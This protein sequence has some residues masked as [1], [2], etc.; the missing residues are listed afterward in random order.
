MEDKLVVDI[1]ER[2]ADSASEYAAAYKCAEDLKPIIEAQH[3]VHL[4]NEV[5]KDLKTRSTEYR[6][7]L[8]DSREK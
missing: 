2:A 6:N 7:E 8:M 5:I 1:I 3:F 4:V